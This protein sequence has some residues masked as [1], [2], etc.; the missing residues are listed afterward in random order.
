M[1]TALYIIVVLVS[2]LVGSFPTAYL[3]VRKWAG[4]DV[5]SLGSGNIG[6]MNTHRATENKRLTIL[7]LLGDMAKG[8]IAVFLARFLLSSSPEA[9][10]LTSAAVVLGHNYSV[11]M[12]FRGGRGLAT[13][14]GAMLIF[15]PLILLMWLLIW[16]PPF[17]ISKILVVG[18]LTATV[19]TPVVTYMLMIT[20]TLGVDRLDVIYAVVITVIVMLKHISKIRMLIKGT[21]PKKY[22]KIRQ[23]D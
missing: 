2:Y 19:L 8:A 23:E 11:Y 20:N 7:V 18:T 13:A 6:T 12:K 10:V 22:W 9:A 15:N 5:T 16:V 17:L 3:V 14:A 1:N 21:E 4:I